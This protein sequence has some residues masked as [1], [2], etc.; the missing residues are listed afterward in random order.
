[1]KSAEDLR[2]AAETRDERYKQAEAGEEV[3]GRN[4]E[5]WERMR[6]EREEAEAVVAR[7]TNTASECNA[8][9]AEAWEKAALPMPVP[10][11]AEEL[12]AVAQ[13]RA[14]EIGLLRE[15]NAA[16]S[17]AADRENEETRFEQRREDVARCEEAEAAA[18][19]GRERELEAFV[20]R[21]YAWE[22]SLEVLPIAEG[23]DWRVLLEA[24][25]DATETPLPLAE[26]IDAAHQSATRTLS[27]E[28]SHC[29]RA[30]RNKPTSVKNCPPKSTASRRPATGAASAIPARRMSVSV[31]LARRFGNCADFAMMSRPRIA[32]A[33]RRRS[34][35]P[36][37][38][39]PGSRPKAR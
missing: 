17:K 4:Q 16:L 28:R 14:Q 6:G 27:E 18:R 33:T 39:M 15:K 8:V 10:N 34:K 7:E 38:S 29:E 23:E 20:A 13:G 35:H 26:W 30:L 1:M 9:L 24:W 11:T 32:P 19:M 25:L 22:E 2:H 21:I 37:C 3:A 5:T 12:D 31:V 36:A